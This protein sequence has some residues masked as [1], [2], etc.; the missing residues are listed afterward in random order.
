[1]K[2]IP[3]LLLLL[4]MLLLGGCGK[5]E[6]PPVPQPYGELKAIMYSRTHGS[7][8][9]YDFYMKLMPEEIDFTDY[10]VESEAFVK[11][12][13]PVEESHWRQAEALM[14]EALPNLWEAQPEK[15]PTFWQRLFPRKEEPFMLDGGDSRDVMLVWK[16]E[17]REIIVGYSCPGGSTTALEEY[18]MQLAQT[19]GQPIINP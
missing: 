13:V 9:G 7:M 10:F 1:M 2:R 6:E 11:E 12:H 5:T 17:E 14:L 15:E 19:L 4:P 18:L 8:Y 3:W 16:T